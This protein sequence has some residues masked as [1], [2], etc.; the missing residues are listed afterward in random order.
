MTETRHRQSATE[1]RRHP[2]QAEY[3][4]FDG[5]HVAMCGRGARAVLEQYSHF[6]FVAVARIIAGNIRR[7]SS[8]CRSSVST[9]VVEGQTAAAAA[10]CLVA[11]DYVEHRRRYFLLAT[12]DT[13]SA[14]GL[15]VVLEDDDS[16]L[17]R[18]TFGIDLA[19]FSHDIP[20]FHTSCEPFW[21]FGAF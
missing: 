21:P 1:D 7:S 12:A 16:R 19:S 3:H 17:F 20:R 4:D 2:R 9:R 11:E 13:G 14:H 10:M 5:R 18:R 6:R 8:P 15:V